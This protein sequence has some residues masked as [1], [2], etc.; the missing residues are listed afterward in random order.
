MEEARGASDRVGGVGQTERVTSTTSPPAGAP[1]GPRFGLKR[2]LLRPGHSERS[3]RVTF[4]EL[5]FDLIFVFALTQL[6][7]YLS[8]NQSPLGALE[9]TI[10]VLALWWVWVYTTWVTNWLDPAKLPVRGAVIVLALIGLVVST[11]IYESFGDRGIVFAIA[12]VTLQLGRTVFMI[13]AVARHDAA[14]TRDFVRVLIWM[15]AAGAFWIV[16]ALL[17]LEFRLAAW[18]IAIVIEYLSAAIGFRVPG[19]SSTRVGDWDI[20]G[21][22]IAERSAL[23]VIIAIGESFLVTGFSFVAQESSVQGV[24]GVLLAF[25]GGVA[26]WWLYFDRAESVGANAIAGSEHPGRLARVAYTYVHAVII[27]GIVLTSVADKELLLH[28]DDG[29]SVGVALTVA[30]GPFLYLAGLALFRWVVAR[31]RLVSHLAGLGMLLLC[32]LVAPLVSTLALGVCTTVVLVIVAA[33]ETRRRIARG[34][35]VADVE[36]AER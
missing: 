34:E 28:P 10:L 33:W 35:A 14:L 7:R 29:V 20:S 36:A 25:V 11:S 21:E 8:E 13:V 9:S 4:I 1:S 22:H 31:E 26:M 24:I 18:I 19:L 2:D 12:Y 32:A 17:P 15:T 23:F 3:D 16:G 5:F 30:G 6:S 27:G